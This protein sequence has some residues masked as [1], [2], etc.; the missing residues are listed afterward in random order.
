[1]SKK[2]TWIIPGL[3]ISVGARSEDRVRLAVIALLWTGAALSFQIISKMLPALVGADDLASRALRVLD[4]DI[5]YHRVS[6]ATITASAAWAFLAAKPILKSRFAGMIS[7]GG[8][9]LCTVAMAATGGRGG[10][11]A[12]TVAALTFGFLRWRKIL[13]LVPV[14]ALLALAVI[15]GLQERLVAGFTQDFTEQ[16][17]RQAARREEMGAIDASGRDRYAITSG[18][19]F[20]WPMI[21]DKAMEAPLFGHGRNAFYRT[22]VVAR[23]ANELRITSFGHPHNAYLE[24][25]IDTGIIGLVVIGA[26]YWLLLRSAVRSFNA[27]SGDTEYIVAS[28][29]LAFLLVNLTAS[30]ASQSFYPK[31]GGTLLWVAIGLALTWLTKGSE[32]QPVQQ[33]DVSARRSITN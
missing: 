18:R 4:R 1:M 12:W 10:M 14:F 16:S 23:L 3:L 15:P 26:F 25:F 28:I 32:S 24:L 22:G 20:V 6:L 5:G 2:A 27:P 17:A 31:Q 11:L 29:A 19:A 33:A 7:L 21:I 8:F 30:I 9:A 13:I